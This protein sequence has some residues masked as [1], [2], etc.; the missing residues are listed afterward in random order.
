MNKFI[1]VSVEDETVTTDF[2]VRNLVDKF[3]I[4]D[5]FLNLFLEFLVTEFVN[6]IKSISVDVAT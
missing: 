5:R 6:Y 3:P 1:S 2:V 4:H